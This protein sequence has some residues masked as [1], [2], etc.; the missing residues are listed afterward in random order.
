MKT[1]HE[2]SALFLPLAD[3]H[4]MEALT[5]FHLEAFTRL[6]LDGFLCFQMCFVEEA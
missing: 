3:R 4:S 5:R 2:E 6:L 1:C